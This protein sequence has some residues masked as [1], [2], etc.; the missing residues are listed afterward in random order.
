[1]AYKVLQIFW[2][3]HKEKFVGVGAFNELISIGNRS[4]CNKNAEIGS[5]KLFELWKPFS[6]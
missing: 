2:Q 1:M 4:C 6:F 5:D 3:E